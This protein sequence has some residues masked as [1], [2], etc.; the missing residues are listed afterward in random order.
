MGFTLLFCQSSFQICLVGIETAAVAACVSSTTK[1]VQEVVEVV[2]VDVE[3]VEWV[4]R[5]YVS[6]CLTVR[7]LFCITRSLTL[8]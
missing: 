7:L 6:K 2:D 8:S 5:K 3:E 1:H 4:Y